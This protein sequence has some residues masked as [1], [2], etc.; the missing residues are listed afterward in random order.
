MPHS[1]SLLGCPGGETKTERIADSKS[2]GATAQPKGNRNSAMLGRRFGQATLAYMICALLLLAY[3][4]SLQS[5]PLPLAT[6]WTSILVGIAIVAWQSIHSAGDSTRVSIVLGEIVSLGF[7]THMLFV[8][9]IP[10]GVFGGTRV[11]LIASLGSTLVFYNVMFHAWFVE[12]TIAYAL[13][14]T[15]V[16]AFVVSIMNKRTK[17]RSRLLAVVLLIGLDFAH[18][19][20]FVFALLFLALA[21]AVPWLIKLAR[22]VGKNTRSL[23]RAVSTREA[24]VMLVLA[25]ILF[26][27]YLSY[28]GEP[29]FK[30][31]VSSLGEVFKPN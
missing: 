28:I 13:L 24:G 19:L 29:A 14:F 12:E 17:T 27:S 30:T 11:A 26:A 7:I 8:I 2:N 1:V 25:G 23:D 20:T 9:P 22:I 18:H 15:F 21:V 16:L 10:A 31:L 4:F 3:L 6:Y 5:R